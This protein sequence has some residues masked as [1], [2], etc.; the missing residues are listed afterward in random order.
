MDSNT[1]NQHTHSLSKVIGERWRKLPDEGKE[2]YRDVAARDAQ[3]HALQ[4]LQAQQQQQQTLFIVSND[5]DDDDTSVNNS[6]AS[7]LDEDA[8]VYS[9]G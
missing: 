1:I 2:F 9:S 6:D 7:P 4:Q 5:D 3:R 8:Y